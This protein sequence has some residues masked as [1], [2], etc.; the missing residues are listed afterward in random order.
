MIEQL[1]TFPNNV[2]AIEV[3]EGFTETDE[4]LF[5]KWYTAKRAA[6]AEQ[7]NVLVKLDEMKLSSTSIKAFFED[8]LW[9]LRNYTHLGH[10]AVVAHSKVAKALVPVDNLFF[11]R[12]SKGRLE[13]YFDVSQMDEAV[14]FVN[15]G[16]A[17]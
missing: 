4:Q 3:I 16:P 5:E 7:V 10:L 12:A 17:A 8:M 14:D 13:R 9:A 11:Q 15:A 6:G 2:L 1:K